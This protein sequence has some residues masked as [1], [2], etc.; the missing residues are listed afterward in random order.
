MATLLQIFCGVT[1]ASP[2][3]C[4]GPGKWKLLVGTCGVVGWLP[5]VNFLLREREAVISQTV[6]FPSS[7][8]NKAILMD[9]VRFCHFACI[10]LDI[11]FIL[12]L[13]FHLLPQFSLKKNWFY[14]SL[15]FYHLQL[16][17]T[18]SAPSNLGIGFILKWFSCK[19]GITW[20][21]V[22][23]PGKKINN[24]PFIK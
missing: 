24:R 10:L 17:F 2:H 13:F 9:R 15:D 1:L 22:P 8:V 16:N 7:A 18:H 23:F 12:S 20:L 14:K 6:E 11:S 19:K 4:E 21:P 5:E 3:V